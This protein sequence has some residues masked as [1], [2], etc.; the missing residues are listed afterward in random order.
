MRTGLLS[1]AAIAAVVFSGA[2]QAGVISETFT[3]FISSGTD[4][5]G[6]FGTAG[7]NLAGDAVTFSFTYDAGLLKADVDAGTD[8][9]YIGLVPSNYE[10]YVDYAGDSAVTDS[11]TIN[12]HMVTISNSPSNAGY[13]IVQGCTE[14][15]CGGGGGLISSEAVNA[16]GAYVEPFVYIAQTYSTSDDLLSQAVVDALVGGGV[17]GG[18]VFVGNGVNG[19]TLNIGSVYVESSTPEPTAWISLALGFGAVSLLKLRRKR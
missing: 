17:T 10:A 13:G 6:Y 3:G 16:S 1:V 2:A 18:I 15:V 4:S 7:T 11:V 19:E 8:G 12:S 14:A 5:L 9:S